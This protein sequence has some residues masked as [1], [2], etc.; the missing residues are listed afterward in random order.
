[1]LVV[2]TSPE[3]SGM[4]ACQARTPDPQASL[5]LPGRRPPPNRPAAHTQFDTESQRVRV[6]RKYGP[7]TPPP[8]GPLYEVAEL[9]VMTREKGLWRGKPVLAR[10]LYVM[11]DAY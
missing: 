7:K 6:S 2:S 8:Q 10:D 9:C 5:G 11:T 3:F 4:Q 1:M